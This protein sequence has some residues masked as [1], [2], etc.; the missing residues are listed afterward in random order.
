MVRRKQF[1]SVLLICA[2][3]MLAV[4]LAD[5][6][7]KRLKVYISADMEGVDGVVTWDVQAMPKGREYEEF[8]RVMT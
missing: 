2:L 7:Q 6:Q 3:V 4:N 1:N 5:A 8:R